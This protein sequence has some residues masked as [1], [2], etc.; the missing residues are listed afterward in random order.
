M[1]KF[2]IADY[3]YKGVRLSLAEDKVKYK[4]RSGINASEMLPDIKADKDEILALLQQGDFWMPVSDGQEDLF[5]FQSMNKT[6]AS[7]NISLSVAVTQAVSVDACQAALT[8][9]IARHPSLS[10]VY[11]LNNDKV[12]QSLSISTL[13]SSSSKPSSLTTNAVEPELMVYG[14]SADHHN[15]SQFDDD[16]EG[17]IK[18]PFSLEGEP[19]IR[20]LIQ[21]VTDET[22]VSTPRSTITM[23]IHHLNADFWSL[24]ILLNDLNLILA[25]KKLPDMEPQDAY[26]D[27]IADQ[28]LTEAPAYEAGEFIEKYQPYRLPDSQSQVEGGELI[29]HMDFNFD[30]ATKQKIQQCAKTYGVTEYVLLTG[31]LYYFLEKISGQS[32]LTLCSPTF[33]RTIEQSAT[34]GYYVKPV[35]MSVNVA[36]STH[37]Q[38][39]FHSVK[40][41]FIQAYDNTHIPLSYLTRELRQRHPDFFGEEFPVFFNWN[42]MP[43]RA[44]E[45][46]VIEGMNI[47]QVGG[48]CELMLTLTDTSDGYTGAW[49]YKRKYGQLISGWHSFFEYLLGE[50]CAVDNSRLEQLPTLGTVDIDRLRAIN[51]TEYHYDTSLTVLDHIHAATAKHGNKTALVFSES[52]LTYAE[53]EQLTNALAARLIEQGVAAQGFVGVCAHRSLELVVAL[54][55]I[56]KAGAAYVPLDP[57]FPE[58]RL[59]DL[60]EDSNIA[61]VITAGETASVAALAGLN[62]IVIDVNDLKGNPVES[63][64]RAT[65]DTPAYMLFTSGS[66]G[67]P[68][69]VILP[70]DALNNR[71]MW[72]QGEYNLCASDRVLQKTPYSFDVSIWEFF[73]PLMQGATLVVAKPEG[74]KDPEYILDIIDQ[75]AITHLHFVPSM[76]QIFLDFCSPDQVTSI[77][78]VYCSGEELTPVLVR[79]FHKKV[80]HAR[81]HNLYGPTEAAIDVS[82]FECKAEHGQLNTIPIGR[83]VTNTRL[84]I[85]DA[86][87]RPVPV[88]S[89]GEIYISGVQLAQCYHNRADLNEE[90]FLHKKLYPGDTETTRIYKTGDLARW[91]IQGVIEYL[92]RND[93]QVKIRGQRVE[94]GEIDSVI[95]TLPYIAYSA[96]LIDKSSGSPALL[97]FQVLSSDYDMDAQ[98]LNTRLRSDLVSLL[99]MHMIPATCIPL[100]EL[101]TTTNGKLDRAR[102]LKFYSDKKHELRSTD[103]SDNQHLHQ[104]VCSAWVAVLGEEAPRGADDNFFLVGGDSIKAIRLLSELKQRHIYVSAEQL[105]KH[106]TLGGLSSLADT[107]ANDADYAEQ[108]AQAPVVRF[109]L[110]DDGQI[111]KPFQEP[112][113]EQYADAYPLTSLQ[114]V[115]YT[116]SSLHQG[117]L[118]HDV[119]TVYPTGAIDQNRLVAV[120]DQVNARH[121]VLRTRVAHS[122]SGDLFQTVIKDAE[123]TIVKIAVN[124]TADFKFHVY[125]EAEKEKIQS[126]DC[127]HENLIRFIHVTNGEQSALIFSFHH[128]IIDGWSVASLIAE[129]FRLLQAEDLTSD[130]LSGD[131]SIDTDNDKNSYRFADYVKLEREAATGDTARQ[132]WQQYLAATDADLIGDDRYGANFRPDDITGIRIPVSALQSQ[133]LVEKSRELGVSVKV[134]CLAAHGL[135]L[136]K[137]LAKENVVTGYVSNGRI[138][139]SSYDQVLGLHLNTL[140]MVMPSLNLSLPEFVQAIRDDEVAAIEHRRYP[141]Y[142]LLQD[143]GKTKLFDTIFNFTNFHIYDDDQLQ[144]LVENIEFHEFTDFNFVSS[145]SMNPRAQQLELNFVF[146][147]QR[148]STKTAIAVAESYAAI[149]DK[150]IHCDS[151]QAV[152]ELL[153]T[154]FHT[155]PVTVA[156]NNHPLVNAVQGPGDSPDDHQHYRL[157]P[158]DKSLP[159]LRAFHGLP[160][161]E[162]H[163]LAN[164]MDVCMINRSETDFIYQEIFE[165]G[166]LE[167]Y[168]LVLPEKPVVFDVG[169]NIG[170]FSLYLFNLYPQARIYAYEPVPRVFEVMQ[171]NKLAYGIGGDCANKGMSSQPGSSAFSFYEGNT[172]ISGQYAAEEDIDLSTSSLLNNSGGAHHDSA[173]LIKDY[174]K[175][176]MVSQT[177]NVELTTLSDEMEQHRIERIHLL[178]VDVEKAEWDVLQGVK[179][180]HWANIDNI[181][182]EVHDIDQRLQKVI[183][184]FQGQ[185]FEVIHSQDEKLKGTNVYSL[186]ASRFPITRR[187]EQRRLPWAWSAKKFVAALLSNLDE[188]VREQLDPDAIRLVPR[189]TSVQDEAVP[190][191]TAQSVS[192][193]SVSPQSRAMMNG[194]AVSVSEQNTQQVLMVWSDILQRPISDKTLSFYDAGGDSISLIKAVRKLNVQYGYQISVADIRIDHS[195]EDMAALGIETKKQSAA[196]HSVSRQENATKK[197]LFVVPFATPAQVYDP[198]I[199]ALKNHFAIERLDV[200]DQLLQDHS[201]AQAS[202]TI[203]ADI[204]DCLNADYVL[205]G[206]SLGGNLAAALSEQYQLKTGVQLPLLLIDSHF[207]NQ[208]LNGY[209]QEDLQALMQRSEQDPY[210]ARRIE[211]IKQY[212]PVTNIGQGLYFSA[213]IN[214][215][216]NSND[217]NSN[218]KDSSHLDF[219]NDLS[220]TSIP[221]GHYDIMEAGQHIDTMA[222]TIAAFIQ[223]RAHH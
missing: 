186:I 46:S 118:Y 103:D 45:A 163:T 20:C 63:V 156:F 126:F 215:N 213:N 206:W 141:L 129:V 134:L 81:L 104:D 22:R 91:T 209:S 188:S 203:L 173:D 177:L 117:V 12:Y 193:Q 135:V 33:G 174:L 47:S 125:L 100:D 160:E 80:G 116:H 18:T 195:A 166:S 76:L 59:E 190:P 189:L 146:N 94:L 58:K 99:P 136:S 66:T 200:A 4:M 181:L 223:Q 170:L 161:H 175:E 70:H 23:V 21:S 168:D 198:L 38:D 157:V 57:A 101:P 133:R 37:C 147:K 128:L 30:Q 75:Q 113:Q 162:R 10:R 53:L 84:H 121:E 169:A 124:P 68:K 108:P 208:N 207:P 7:Y 56:M 74:H 27:T 64:N 79:E 130:N 44:E 149:L 41:A 219:I 87:F 88:G 109:S 97:S 72:M 143:K 197:L 92:G 153:L 95:A 78:N 112:F 115:M 69:G 42:A 51:A 34:V 14:N 158:V 150:L 98:E 182:I 164:D 120:I 105:Y 93:N 6:D 36:E 40:K 77:T 2:L 154:L 217:N 148:L 25:G 218:N 176:K 106:P 139:H 122:D 29:E 107:A 204:E 24:G 102:L 210:F 202:E 39:L 83:P 178:K 180:E 199:N 140:P 89:V 191:A 145:F 62:N 11:T 65:P 54:L 179:P 49:H 85:L 8:Q 123:P 61:S 3:L 19:L 201:L 194:K 48:F 15:L 28:F 214:G 119:F 60:V 137:V 221:L 155:D 211:L 187:T 35:A 196:I 114:E 73:W 165:D 216:K 220:I 110:L 13:G 1:N 9:L 185:G 152:S 82:Y 32:A 127:E 5:L 171:K 67:K 31:A 192:P 183:D 43:E 96:T 17:F 142:N 212:R 55:A 144:N 138:E 151:Q 90:R 52:S 86:K 222:Q 26:I 16:R 71:L 50:I 131:A 167:N 172:L 184:L 205:A 111:E 159:Q 132:F